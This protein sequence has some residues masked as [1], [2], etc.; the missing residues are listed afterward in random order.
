MAGRG[1]CCGAAAPVR[2][3]V[4]WV[5][6]PADLPAADLSHLPFLCVALPRALLFEPARLSNR[7]AAALG[8]LFVAAAVATRRFYSRT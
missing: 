1:G 5:F 7:N 4:L 6:E 2:E 3:D 8:A